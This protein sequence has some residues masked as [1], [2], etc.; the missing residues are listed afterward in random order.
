M[1]RQEHN[2]NRELMFLDGPH[3]FEAILLRHIDIE[4]GHIRLMVFNA[5]QRSIAV[6]SFGNHDQRWISREHLSQSLVKTG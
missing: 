4:H 6:P 3:H 5:L 1:H 2:R